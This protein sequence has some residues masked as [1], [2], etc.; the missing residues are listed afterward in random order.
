MHST[1]NL[2]QVFSSAFFPFPVVADQ[3]LMMQC[4]HTCA[5][6]FEDNSF[7]CECAAPFVLADDGM[8]CVMEE[9]EDGEEDE[10]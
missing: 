10:R 8:D 4:S 3:C 6:N 9:D 2:Q 7:G 5:F 1:P